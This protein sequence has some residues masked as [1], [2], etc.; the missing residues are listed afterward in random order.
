[1]LRL[2][3][4]DFVAIRLARFIAE[5]VQAIQLD[6]FIRARL[7]ARKLLHCEI[8]IE[9]KVLNR[10]FRVKNPAIDGQ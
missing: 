8:E 10:Y 3:V 5:R 4:V 6:S 7:A 1:L 9:K 2:T